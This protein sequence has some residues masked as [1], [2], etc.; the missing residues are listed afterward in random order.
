MTFQ[1]LIAALSA[2]T[3]TDDDAPHITQEQRDDIGQGLEA[4][5][6]AVVKGEFERAAELARHLQ[7]T[8]GLPKLA[9]AA[10]LTRCLLAF[11]RWVA[12]AGAWDTREALAE[13][14]GTPLG[15]GNVSKV[16]QHRALA[17]TAAVMLTQRNWGLAAAA[18]DQWVQQMWTV[19]P[20]QELARLRDW[21]DGLDAFAHA[22]KLEGA[23]VALALTLSP[24]RLREDVLTVLRAADKALAEP[25][26]AA[27]LGLDALRSSAMQLPPGKRLRTGRS[28]VLH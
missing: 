22:Q 14:Y 15:A 27:A 9:T 23:T 2:F 26:G 24:E 21:A 8:F 12:A 20:K 17:G 3:V 1:E 25:P 4:I 18:W 6:A 7:V 28:R 13:V 10:E 19:G 16:P 11:Q 5:D